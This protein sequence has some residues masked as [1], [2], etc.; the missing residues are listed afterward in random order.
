[1]IYCI[2]LNSQNVTTF[3]CDL[4]ETNC[5]GYTARHLDQHIAEHENCIAKHFV[6]QH[7]RDRKPLPSPYKE[8]EEQI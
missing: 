7:D 2:L 4:C 3:K 1:M 5:V 6:T 8:V